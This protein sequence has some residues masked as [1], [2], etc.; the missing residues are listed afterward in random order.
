[1]APT[2]V[3]N[4]ANTGQSPPVPVWQGSMWTV[5]VWKEEGAA[6]EVTSPPTLPDPQSARPC[7]SLSFCQA[8][9]SRLPTLVPCGWVKITSSEPDA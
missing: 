1:M 2:R 7:G 8:G 6:T 9:E 3:P 4:T 5:H